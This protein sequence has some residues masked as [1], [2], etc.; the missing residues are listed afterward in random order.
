MIGKMMRDDIHSSF[1]LASYSMVMAAQ[2]KSG[3]P[4]KIWQIS[5]AIEK[6]L[7]REHLP[8]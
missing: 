7:R 6:R 2:R 8:P 1:P 4:I 3:I 5:I